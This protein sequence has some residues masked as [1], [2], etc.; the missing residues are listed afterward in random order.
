VM[1]HNGRSV[2]VDV[3]DDVYNERIVLWRSRQNRNKDTLL[4]E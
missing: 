3:S 4:K 1:D 2:I